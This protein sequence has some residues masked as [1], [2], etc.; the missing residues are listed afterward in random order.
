MTKWGYSRDASLFPYSKVISVL[1]HVH[2]LKK[3]NPMTMSKCR[4]NSGQNSTSFM[5][6]KKK[7]LLSAVHRPVIPELREAEA[8]GLRGQEIETILVNMV[9]P[10]LH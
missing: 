10:R 1:H 9:K 7:T 5:I 4:R 2:R 3:E 8:G 6:K